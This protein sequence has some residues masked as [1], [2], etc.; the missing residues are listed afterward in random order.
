MDL[1]NKILAYLL[2]A[3][4]SVSV[5][6]PNGIAQLASASEKAEAWPTEEFSAPCL[7][8]LGTGLAMEGAYGLIG[9]MHGGPVTAGILVLHK[10]NIVYERYGRGQNKNTPH[11]M[12]SVTKSVVSALVGIAIA[13]GKIKSVDQKVVDFFPDAKIAP[14][15]ESKRSMTVKHLLT[16]TSGLPG[17][18]DD[19]DH[20]WWDAK[21]SGKAA[22]ETP[23]Y[24]KPGERFNYNSGAAMQTLACLVSRAV[25]MNLFEY[26]KSKLFKPL[27]MASVTWDAA[28]DGSNY[29]GFGLSMTARD[30]ARFGY[31]YLK[32]GSWDGKQIIPAS[33]IAAT[34][35]PSQH[36]P[37][38]GYLFWTFNKYSRFEGTYE[39]NGSF[40]QYID[41]FPEWD[42]VVVR[43]GDMGWLFETAATIG[44]KY[45][46]F[47][48]I[49]PKGVPLEAILGPLGKLDVLK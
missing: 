41:V 18:G 39:A 24:T 36:H 28:A 10:G 6:L 5:A 42:T 16:M 26:A 35:P 34:S 9:L 40:G 8:R 21:D 3:V 31:L 11:E 23:Q 33:Y 37:E 2:S 13:E 4:F 44:V 45:L 14:G 22:F 49:L 48:S 7:P 20:N 30:M 29:G 43:I 27:G 12:Y 15:Q 1:L 25:K 47:D 38:F 19:N 46:G 32:Q 17:D